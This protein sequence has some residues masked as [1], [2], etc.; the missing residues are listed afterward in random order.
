MGFKS[1]FSIYRIDAEKH[2]AGIKLEEIP[3]LVVERYNQK[4]QERAADNPRIVNVSIYTQ[5]ANLENTAGLELYYR[6]R[7]HVHPWVDMFSGKFRLEASDFA[8]ATN[9]VAVFSVTER[10]LYVTT[11]NNG[12]NLIS[13]YIDEHFPVGLAKHLLKPAFSHTTTRDISGQLLSQSQFLRNPSP[14]SATDAFGRIWKNISGEIRDEMLADPSLKLIFG[15]KRRMNAEIGT[16]IKLRSKIDSDALVLLIRRLDELI[17][18]PLS[19]EA[20]LAFA[21]LDTAKKLGPRDREIIDSLDASLIK[22][23]YDSALNP[24]NSLDF[25]FCHIKLEE[26]LS[27]ESYS[28]TPSTLDVEEWD[29]PAESDW[30]LHHLISEGALDVS[31]YDAFSESLESI[32]IVADHPEDSSLN[33]QGSFAEHLHGELDLDGKKYFLVDKTWYSV[34]RSFL[35]L[36]DKQMAY[37]QTQPL[38]FQPGPLDLL[39]WDLTTTKREEDYNGLYVNSDG[40]LVGD[41][42]FLQNIELF[43]LLFYN[44]TDVYFIH[45][46]KGFDVKTRDLCSQLSNS[47][48]IIEGDIRANKDGLK[49]YYANGVVGGRSAHKRDI[50]AA[51]SSMGESAFL[52]IV[53]GGRIRNYVF[54]VAENRALATTN[55]GEYNSNIAKIE[56]LN[57]RETMKRHDAVFKIVNI[58]LSDN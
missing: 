49:S 3:S 20:N 10:G 23:V 38:L 54:A 13:P 52:D 58:G 6:R 33:T 4:E 47:A 25:D 11:A 31:G 15:V 28:V 16:S 5:A 19:E 34:E 14:I 30:I 45:V 26:Y 55:P 1:Q 35:D 7:R 56:L 24:L 36:V 21:F 32:S 29:R 27:A 39:N 50:A 51:F 8:V 22:R 40:Y 2:F 53:A 46:K 18:E 57:L 48:N 17:A 41:Q 9:D 42:V 37:L 12:H 44:A 43:D